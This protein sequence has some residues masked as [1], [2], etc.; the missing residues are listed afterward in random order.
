MATRAMSRW[1]IS[2]W[3]GVVSAIA[4]PLS[5]RSPIAGVRSARWARK[6]SARD[7]PRPADERV[8]NEGKGDDQ[9]ETRTLHVNLATNAPVT[10]ISVSVRVPG[11]FDSGRMS[12]QIDDVGWTDVHDG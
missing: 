6:E 2:A 5:T 3:M 11:S 1:G 7:R 10:G 12:F 8:G 9:P 4:A